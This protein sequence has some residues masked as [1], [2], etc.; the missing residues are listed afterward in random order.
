MTLPVIQM[1]RG[2]CAE[3]EAF[4]GDR[5]YEFNAKATGYTDGETFAA[6]QRDDAGAIL[7]GVSGY[8]WGGVC[9]VSNLWVSE[10]H[11]GSGFGAALLRL[12]EQSA[13]D[14]GCVVALL[15]THSFQSP[16]FYERMGYEAGATVKDHPIGH[17][18]VFYSKRL[19]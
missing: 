4:L 7:A 6:V 9:F 12:A 15:S 18:N 16:G 10:A 1:Q 17:S 3:I 5:I 8:T 13:R 19:T 14:K 2:D 11:R